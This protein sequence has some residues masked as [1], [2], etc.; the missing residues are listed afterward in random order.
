MTFL[1]VDSATLKKSIF[2]CFNR[3]SGSLSGKSMF[4]VLKLIG[5]FAIPVLD[6]VGRRSPS[7]FSSHFPSRF[8]RI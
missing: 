6:Q 7:F 8:L 5:L 1:S 2:S 3:N 4:S